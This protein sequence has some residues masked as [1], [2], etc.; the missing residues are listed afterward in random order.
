MRNLNNADFNGRT[1]RVDFADN[2]NVKS[3]AP[4]GAG[5]GIGSGGP[6]GSSFPP[7]AG[8]GG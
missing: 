4:S 5:M 3:S 8:T 7:N 6:S 1:L 2:E